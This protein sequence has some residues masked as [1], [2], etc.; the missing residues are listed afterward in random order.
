MVALTQTTK[1]CAKVAYMKRRALG[2]RCRR[3]PAPSKE[4]DAERRWY[5]AKCSIEKEGMGSDTANERERGLRGGGQERN[6]EMQG[7]SV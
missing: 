1:A 2:W 5:S 7:L 3:A 6:R 4:R